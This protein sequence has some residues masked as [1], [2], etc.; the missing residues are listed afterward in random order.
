MAMTTKGHYYHGPF[1]CT[2]F[3]LVLSSWCSCRPRNLQKK[4][5]GVEAKML[6]VAQTPK[7]GPGSVVDSWC[8]LVDA[9]LESMVNPSSNFS[10]MRDWTQSWSLTITTLFWD[11]EGS[12]GVVSTPVV[13][14]NFHLNSSPAC[15]EAIPVATQLLR[16][17]F[18]PEHRR[19]CLSAHLAPAPDLG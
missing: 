18:L 14:L 6:L 7:L 3:F 11:R 9:G 2:H 13:I 19:Q 17:I 10:S 15:G 12:H 5:A 4:H 8:M 16:W 1:G